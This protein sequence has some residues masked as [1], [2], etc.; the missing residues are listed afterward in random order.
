[1]Y[2]IYLQNLE[3]VKKV[4]DENGEELSADDVAKKLGGKKQYAYFKVKI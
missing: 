4:V 2:S 3:L 1:M